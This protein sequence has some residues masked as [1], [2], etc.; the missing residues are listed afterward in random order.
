VRA[1]LT[2]TSVVV[3]SGGLI[4]SEVDKEIVA[5]NIES[6]TC[7]GLNGVGS[8]IWKL[9]ATPVRVEEICTK[10]VAEYQVDR[11]VCERDVMDLLEELRA[12]KLVTV[13][14]AP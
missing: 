6:G 13:T 14:T 4:E 9:L 2:P 10:L 7:Y 12:E 1:I 8:V 3:R 11:D 5:L